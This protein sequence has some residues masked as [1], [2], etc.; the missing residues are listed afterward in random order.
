MGGQL[1]GRQLPVDR[2]RLAEHRLTNLIQSF[3]LLGGLGAL[4]GLLGWTIGGATVATVAVAAVVAL[5]WLNPA[6]SPHWLLRLYRAQSIDQRRAPVLIAVL[7]ELARRAEL[8]RAPD[9][10]YLPSDVMNAFAVGNRN[11]AAIA[12]SDGLLRRLNMRELAAV[13][14]HEISHIR[15]DD[16][17]LM[18]F[19]DVASRMTH[20]LALVGALL[21]LVNVPLIVLGAV[22][23]S[24][25]AIVVL[26][27]APAVSALLQ[28]ALSRTREYH[29]DAGAADLTGDPA[30]L[31]S[32]LAKM[33]RVQGGLFE[34]VLWPQK[35]RPTEPSA[36]R[37]HPPTSERINRL[38]TLTGRSAHLPLPWITSGEIPS[39]L[40]ADEA[41]RPRWRGRGIWY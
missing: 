7:A 36:L 12:L 34:R 3:L 24:W 22:T 8:P 26:I 11:A 5:Y 17:R 13:M 18:G 31:A 40:S 4:M 6:V 23:I 28:L 32:A 14:A 16:V 37:S 20:T 27:A 39:E 19:A 25:S 2:E 1:K 21:V 38:L 29:A 15:H 33:E 10:Y 41:I 35:R 9:L 30:A